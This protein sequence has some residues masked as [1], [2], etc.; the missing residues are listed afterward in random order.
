MSRLGYL[1]R[2][3]KRTLGTLGTLLV[4]SGLVVGSG[5]FFTDTDS[6][7]SNS[8]SA[9][10]FGITMYG[11]A[12]PAFDAYDC[13]NDSATAGDACHDTALETTSAGDNTTFQ[14]DRLVP[15]PKTYVRR[16]SIEN[17]GDVPADVRLKAFNT[18][19]ST[20]LVAAL[21]ATVQRVGAAD[22]VL[23]AG[24]LTSLDET[25][26]IGDGD[27][28]VYELTLEFPS[29]GDQDA[30]EAATASF[31]LKAVAN[32]ENEGTPSSVTLP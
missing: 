15:G 12:T 10:D 26:T 17:D 28:E 7:V 8:A 16:F 6:S 29:D 1:A 9:A 24:N 20:D 32:D 14:I 2:N 27:T 5:A 18:S 4:A 13:D 31:T 30:L 11:S 25:V 19:G 21:E 22:P 3:P 23:D